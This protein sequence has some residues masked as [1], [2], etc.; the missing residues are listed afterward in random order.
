MKYKIDYKD[1]DRRIEDFYMN[2]YRVLKDVLSYINPGY[3]LSIH[4]FTPHYED[5]PERKFEVGVL[6][7]KKGKLAENVSIILMKD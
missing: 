2:Y 5:N 7:R 6:Y 4:S 3:V 1:R